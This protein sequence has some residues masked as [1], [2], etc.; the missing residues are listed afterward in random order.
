M[1]EKT[2]WER[3]TVRPDGLHNSNTSSG[4]EQAH[5]LNASGCY[6]GKISNL[7]VPLKGGRLVNMGAPVNKCGIGPLG[8][9]QVVD[10][11][12]EWPKVAVLAVVVALGTK[13]ESGV[14][15]SDGRHHLI[16]FSLEND[17]GAREVVR[18]GGVGAGSDML[19]VMVQILPGERT[20]RGRLLGE[21][22]QL[23]FCVLEAI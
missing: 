15:L 5:A 18:R 11:L 13:T 9:V 22:I 23:C 21:A 19:C 10:H 4:E 7:V 6:L 16:R 20:S 8:D 3:E 14:G 2:S 17:E 1:P 12:V